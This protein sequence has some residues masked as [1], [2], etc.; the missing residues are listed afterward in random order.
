[1]VVIQ[2]TMAPAEVTKHVWNKSW[3]AVV[4]YSTLSPLAIAKGVATK[5][6]NEPTGEPEELEEA[7]NVRKDVKLPP[8]RQPT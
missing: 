1:M 3:M 2:G 5:P 6:S 4:V 7:G 8:T